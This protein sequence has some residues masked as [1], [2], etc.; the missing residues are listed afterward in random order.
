MLLAI[1]P[2]SILSILKEETD[3]ILAE[4]TGVASRKQGLV[5]C[6]QSLGQFTSLL[7]PPQLVVN[8]ANDAASKA[9][10]F[11]RDFKAGTGSVGMMGLNDSSTRAGFFFFMILTIDLYIINFIRFY[12]FYFP[13]C[14]IY[15]CLCLN[16]V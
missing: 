6:L 1:I 14:I 7:S 16:M 12:C 15:V 4:G 2:L 11:V 10:K 8:A 9:A 13:V 3:R 5:A